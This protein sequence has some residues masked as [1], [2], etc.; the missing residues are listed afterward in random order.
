MR[1]CAQGHLGTAKLLLHQG[2][3]VNC[4][5]RVR[6]LHRI[7]GPEQFSEELNLAVW[8][9]ACLLNPLQLLVAYSM[10]MMNQIEL[11]AQIYIN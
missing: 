1:A 9:S 7:A 6:V 10:I 5:D 2:A 8:W 4:Q 11:N 3:R